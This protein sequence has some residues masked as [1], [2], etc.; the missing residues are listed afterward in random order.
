M[1]ASSLA[2]SRTAIRPETDTAGDS[3]AG[4]HRLFMPVILVAVL[5]SVITGSMVNVLLPE[6]KDVFGASSAGISWVITAYSLMYAIGIPLVGRLSDIVGSR[7]LFVAGLAGFAAGTLVSAIAPNLAILI[8]GRLI[9]GAGGAAIPAMALVL[10]ARSVPEERRGQAMG[11]MG[12]AVGAGSAIGPFAGGF[13]GELIGW[14]GL[15]VLP[16]VVSLALVPVVRKAIPN[17]LGAPGSSFDLAGGALLGATIGLA[18]LGITRGDT[19]PLTLLAF[20]GSAVALGGFVWRINHAPAPFA[21]PALF[22]NSAYIRLLS[23]AAFSMMGYMAALVLTPLMLVEY[24]NLS[25]GEAGL[26]LTPSAIA[27][28]IGSRY[29]GGISD[30]VGPRTPV[31]AGTALVLAAAGFMSTFGAGAQA[32]TVAAGM[33]LVG[34]GLSMVSPPLN[35]AASRTLPRD[36]TGIGMG[37]FSGFTFMGGGIGAAVI[38]A[39][40]AARERANGDALNP[41]HD[42]D[43]AV[44]SDAYLLVAAI[45]AI[46]LALGWSIRRTGQQG[47]D[48]Q[49]P[50]SQT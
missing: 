42:G 34:A 4:L 11:L 45:A 9:Q 44:W 43:G 31:V 22:R 12:S 46:A 25:A 15:F 49:Q 13:L 16:F 23:T 8:I 29:A 33:S 19:S 10:I 18:L 35:S 6:M 32:V 1:S 26:A 50:T 47:P 41:F 28:A 24:N 2:P 20:A 17:T 48:S 40:I 27:L 38:G 14:R 21:P 30:R 39:W 3:S 5:N 36:Q 7:T 37:L